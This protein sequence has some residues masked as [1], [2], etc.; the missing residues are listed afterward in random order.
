L[1]IILIYFCNAQSICQGK[2]DRAEY[3]RRYHSRY[4]EEGD[5]QH[6]GGYAVAAT[7][8]TK[9]TPRP[10]ETSMHFGHGPMAEAALLMKESWFETG[11]D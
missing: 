6:D 11:L 3:T 7:S 2:A 10:V 5:Q 9:M 1:T 4:E 8:S